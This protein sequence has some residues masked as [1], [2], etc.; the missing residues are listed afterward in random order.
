MQYRKCCDQKEQQQESAVSAVSA[1]SSFLTMSLFIASFL[2]PVLFYSFSNYIL[3][4][5]CWPG[6]HYEIQG[7]LEDMAIVLRA[8]VIGTCHNAW[9]ELTF[10]S[11]TVLRNF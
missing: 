4:L 8:G 1:A 6:I 7:V 9:M 2:C 11:W 5:S 3:F 10:I